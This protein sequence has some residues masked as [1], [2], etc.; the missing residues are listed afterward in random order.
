MLGHPSWV[1]PLPKTPIQSI[2]CSFRGATHHLLHAVHKPNVHVVYGRRFSGRPSVMAPR[3]L[4][5][6]LLL[7]GLACGAT[8]VDGQRQP[9]RWAAP[10]PAHWALRRVGG[11]PPP[12][13]TVA[14]PSLVD[15]VDTAAAA[16]DHTHRDSA[17]D[18]KPFDD[19]PTM[20]VADRRWVGF[21]DPYA[22]HDTC[23]QGRRSPRH[24]PYTSQPVL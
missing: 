10:A 3:L 14:P 17:T 22:P 11:D 9:A 5:L 12:S 19:S 2:Q 8:G 21:K 13:E 15:T 23:T 1:L 18:M 16:A 6:L 20:M 7:M 24:A 4:L